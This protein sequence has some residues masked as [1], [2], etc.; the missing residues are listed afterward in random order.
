MSGWA[1]PG[2]AEGVL[3]WALRVTGAVLGS[4]QGSFNCVCLDYV[5]RGNRGPAGLLAYS[6]VIGPQNLLNRLPGF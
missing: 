4:L 2:H 3:P 1:K 6:L 5:S